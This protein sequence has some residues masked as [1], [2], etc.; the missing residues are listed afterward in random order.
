MATKCPGCS[1]TLPDSTSECPECGNDPGSGG[2]TTDTP[3]GEVGD[4]LSPPADRYYTDDGDDFLADSELSST[5]HVDGQSLRE[6]VEERVDEVFRNVMEEKG[7]DENTIEQAVEDTLSERDHQVWKRGGSSGEE[8]FDAEAFV[9]DG[10]A[11][12]VQQAI[13]DGQADGQRY[14][15]V[16]EAEAE[17]RDRSTV[18]D[19]LDSRTQ[20]AE[21]ED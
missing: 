21:T 6:L 11:T 20:D 12:D 3:A 1:I 4:A 9:R 2:T 17:Y 5:L 8:G 14:D 15:V 10:N 7:Y 18:Y 16:R 19:A 13:R